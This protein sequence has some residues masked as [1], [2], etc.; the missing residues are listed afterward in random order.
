VK[1][2]APVKHLALIAEQVRFADATER[3]IQK[4]GLVHVLIGGPEHGD[5]H[6]ALGKLR[7]NLA[8]QA[9]AHDRACQTATDNEYLF[10]HGSAP[11]R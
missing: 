11:D 4:P 9:I 8:A 3:D 5:D 6:L 10:W 2:H 1:H 7:T